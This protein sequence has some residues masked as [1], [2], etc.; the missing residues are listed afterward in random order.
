M[1][2]ILQIIGDGRP[3]GGTTA[4]LTLSHRLAAYG[5][6]I[7][8]ITQ[9]NSYLWT[10]GARAGFLVF[11]LDFTSRKNTC[12]V[13]SQIKR[14]WLRTQSSIL[15]VH[16]GRAGLPVA[17]IPHH[18]PVI[19]T[20]H[21]FHFLHKG[22]GLYRLAYLAEA[23][24]MTRADCT[25]FVSDADRNTA[26][27]R[28]LLAL[29]HKHRVIKNAVEV[30]PI[31]HNKEYDIGFIGRLHFQK[32]P[33]FL[34]DILKAMRPTR[35]SLCVIGGGEL[36]KDLE[37]RLAEE[38]LL[39]QVTITGECDRRTALAMLSKCRVMVLPSRWEG[40]PIALIEAMLLGVPVV[41]SDIPGTN[42]ITLHGRTG[43]LVSAFNPTTYA[44]RL[45]ELLESPAMREFMAGT[46]RNE[47]ARNYSVDQMVSA[48]LD[49]YRETATHDLAEQ[50]A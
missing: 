7:V 45:R 17:L 13:A 16:G 12:A 42:E 47:A 5:E 15:H 18:G 41:A 25:V 8:L 30:D 6:E 29:A 33:L 26:E 49:L 38:G 20:V 50:F 2:R 46:A 37:T 48:Y 22:P 27:Q 34:V 21:G 3:G 35:P 36:A 23:L 24:C 1:A 10:E 4:V 43:F 44:G 14:Q 9:R 19:Y 28:K 40:H 31:D 11:G 32:N 39:A